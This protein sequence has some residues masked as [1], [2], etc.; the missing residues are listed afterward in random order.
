MLQSHYCSAAVAVTCHTLALV[1]AAQLAS[2]VTTTH[3][4]MELKLQSSGR[5]LQLPQSY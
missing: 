1:Q 4:T 5:S 2:A 3:G